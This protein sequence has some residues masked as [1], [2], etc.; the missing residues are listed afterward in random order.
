MKL[1]PLTAAL[2]SGASILGVAGVANIASAASGNGVTSITPCDAA[3]VCSAGAAG[4]YTVSVGAA[5]VVT[6]TGTSFNTGW[7][8]NVQTSTGT[9]TRTECRNGSAKVIAQATIQHDQLVGKT[10]TR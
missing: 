6:I 9:Q 5:N 8:C 10:V 4:S 7:A 1:N 2:F 3:G